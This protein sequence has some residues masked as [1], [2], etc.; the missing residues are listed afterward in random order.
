[1][2][3]QW[4]AVCLA[5]SQTSGALTPSELKCEYAVNPLGVDAAQPRFSWV[6]RSSRRGQVQSA[7]QI[8][9]AGSEEKLNAGTGDKWDS[10]KVAS[11]RSVNLAYQGSPLASGEKCWWKVRVWDRDG[12][13]TAYSKPGTF[14]MGLLRPGDW[15]GKW[16]AMGDT[17]SAPLLRKEF[18]LQ[19]DVK[20]AKVYLCGLGYYELYVNG[21]KVGD[22]V[23][24]PATT[25]Y[26][27]DL[28]FELSARVLYV[29]YDVTARLKRGRNALGVLLGNGWYSAITP[30]VGR[31]PYGDRPKLI[32]QMDL[33]FTDGERESIVSDQAW[34]ASGGPILA[35][36]ICTGEVY[37]ARLEKPGW[38]T[39]G[40]DDSD[41]D[42][43]LPV[44]PPGG[45]LTSQMMPP[46]KVMET[47]KPVR[48]LKPAE[49]VYVY[50]FGQHFSGWTRL[51]ATGPRGTR[52]T[53]R[54]A[55][56][57][58]DDGR[59][60][61][62]ANLESQQTDTYILKGEGTE[63][64]E[65]RFTLHGFRYVEMTGFPGTPTETS[66]EGRF[67][68]SALETDGSFTCSNPLI[69]RIHH[70]VLWTFMT[71][72]QGIP[73]DAAERHERFGW[74]G[75][76]GFTWE[77]YIYNFDMAAFTTKW[78]IDIR[79]TQNANGELSV[80]APIAYRANLSDFNYGS[81]PCWISTYPLLVW[82]MH[83]YY[84]DERILREHYDGLKRMVDFKS[85]KAENHILPYGLGDHMEPQADGKSSFAPKHTPAPLTST[86]YY[87]YDAWIVAQVAGILGEAEDSRHYS[88]LAE[89]IKH[90]FNGK[91]L[92][93]ATNQYAGGSQTSN[94]IALYF[95]MVP[96]GREKAVAKNLAHDI[97]ITHKGHL[98]TGIIGINA[99][100]QALP[101]FG[102]ASVMY[103]IATQ[104]TFPSW[105]YEI[106]RGATTL[107]ETWQG[108]ADHCLNMKMFGSVEKF[109][110][111]DLAGISPAAPGYERITVKP[112]VVGDLKYAK[113]SVKTVR[114][115]VA[116]DW[117]RDDRSLEM[118]VTI[119]A[120]G[121]A[122][123]SVPK[124]E[125]KDV[126]ITEGRTTIWKDGAYVREVV[127]I[128]GGSETNDYVT[129][130]VGS[131]LYCFTL[132]GTPKK[133]SP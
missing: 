121:R 64:W 57:V 80:T 33:E 55:G 5:L 77:D 12:N 105:G 107:W 85:T 84:G 47:I 10:G 115:L 60:D 30:P 46:V 1:M 133:G 9:V 4:I 6:L 62:R 49:N 111:K 131:G 113:A 51:R 81:Y 73:Q 14:E 108:D 56:R 39:A 8:L 40:Y 103:E 87:Y 130:D 16:I 118:K 18:T 94:A 35:D 20:R 82:Y 42:G 25:Y 31:Q 32:L 127:G 17:A 19:K 37:D 28:P 52:V 106:E 67:V 24:D 53:L 43:A 83:Q 102:L 78:L 132:T 97:M 34:K 59:L 2:I 70:N 92:D 95:G 89:N 41:W 65:P 119:P 66:L 45:V 38:T 26:N 123:V 128:T 124:L 71:S 117:K 48:I 79:N 58:Y 129:F 116:V 122:K 98:S 11:D 23:L 63:V 110:Y 109:F 104:T 114:G 76:T 99:L 120:N 27:N 54:H 74:Q 36:E 93:Q 96:E 112:R 3:T 75:D 91:F 100:E 29:T 15:E 61:R 68:R 88:A 125:L 22:H 101:E 69:N 126:A 72:L 44:E 13:T 21:S 90:A 50:D 86:A 7:Y